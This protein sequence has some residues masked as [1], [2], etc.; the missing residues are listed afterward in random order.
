VKVVEPTPLMREAAD[1]L[2][3]IVDDVVVIGAIAVTVALT[4]DIGTAS[5][6]TT[7]RA[8]EATRDLDLVIVAPTRDVDLA[9][10]ASVAPAVVR[11]LTEQGLRPS[12]E[13]GER[14][15]TWERGDLK[16][17]LMTSPSGP[18]MGQVLKLPVQSSLSIVQDHHLPVAFVDDPGETRIRCATAGALVALKRAAFG[19]T[20]HD[21]TPV[22]R[23]PHD[24]LQ[25]LLG[26]RADLLAEAAGEYVV[27]SNLRAIVEQLG[28]DTP[29]RDAAAREHLRLGLASNER[30][31]RLAVQRA[32][33]AFGR[34]LETSSPGNRR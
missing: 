11:Q 4:P 9:V 3:P 5:G 29:A 21:G 17:Q 19:R 27:R 31:A 14:G 23:D 22:D 10:E 12:E 20:R 33:L 6:S 30:E 2:A 26:A 24:A 25:L 15:F 1:V 18:R 16:V 13:P 7:A 8:P 32:A 28:S 34:E